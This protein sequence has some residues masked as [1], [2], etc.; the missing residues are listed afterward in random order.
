MQFQEANRIKMHLKTV[1]LACGLALALFISPLLP[2]V[3]FAAEAEEKPARDP[4]ACELI[5]EGKHIE[6]LTLVNGQGLVKE[7]NH[8]GSSVFLPRGLYTVQSIQVEGGY[9]SYPDSLNAE[10]KLS[11]SPSEPCKLKAG[12]P[13]ISTVSVKRAGRLLKLDYKLCDAEGRKYF[14]Y[15]RTT[16]PQFAIYQGE[17]LIGSGAFEYG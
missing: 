4:S 9:Y 6:K 10:N 13:L 11:L 2:A 1:H 3:V 15:Q 5:I 17:Q 7:I 16:T 8:P 14:N 12:A